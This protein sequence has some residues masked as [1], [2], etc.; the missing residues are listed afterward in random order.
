M[1]QIIMATFE[2]GVLKPHQPLALPP[3]TE[4]RLIVEAASETTE[5]KD[6]AWDEW[7]ELCAANPI[8]SGGCR[9]TRDQLHERD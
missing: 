9:L 7:E 1:S 6:Q 8:D 2:D 3:R 5:M 4:V